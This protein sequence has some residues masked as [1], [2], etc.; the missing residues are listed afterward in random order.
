M[1]KMYYYKLSRQEFAS[2]ISEIPRE[3]SFFSLFNHYYEQPDCSP[4]S[5]NIWACWTNNI[6]D[7]DQLPFFVVVADDDLNDF[8]AWTLNFIPTFR[9]ITSFLRVISWSVFLLIHEES[10]KSSLDIRSVLVGAILGE[11]LIN[12]TGR[13]FV[14]SLPL[15]AFE[16]TY[17]FAMSKALILGFNQKIM[18]Y[19]S[20]GWHKAREYTDQPAR[21]INSDSLEKIWCIILRINY[22][23]QQVLSLPY[24]DKV[25]ALEDAC[26]SIR[27]GNGLSNSQWDILSGGR[28]NDFSIVEMTRSTK[29]H[30]IEIFENIIKKLSIHKYDEL[31]TSFLV[32]Y[33]AS[34]VSSGS[35]EHAHLITPLQK[36]LPSAML[37]Y[38]ICAGLS[39][40]N[41]I[42]TDYNHLGLRIFGIL[43]YNYDLMSSPSCDISLSELEVI[44]NGSPQSRAFRHAQ[45]S[46]LRIELVPMVTTVV[47]WQGTQASD[48]QLSLFNGNEPKILPEKNKSY[49]AKYLNELAMKL[50]ESLSIT[51]TL[52]GIKTESLP[53]MG[54]QPRGKRRS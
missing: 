32:G 17:S 3:R 20:N 28:I 30:R 43:N 49:D 4:E 38:G 14:S 10:P 6:S 53:K 47:R 50:K 19:I 45:A 2:I 25:V 44:F 21:R 12:T 36:E 41:S 27:T 29:E 5:H 42:L 7:G 9:P 11:T 8:L 34:M 39:P 33:L 26:N 54:K 48:S 35:L 31:Y 52:L 24:N 15:T 23:T 46:S 22:K 51:E 13:G 18:P 1:T 16:S 37:W 40:R